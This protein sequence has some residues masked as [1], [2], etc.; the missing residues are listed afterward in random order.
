[1]HPAPCQHF[2]Q[3]VD[4][5]PSYRS[6]CTKKILSCKKTALTGKHVGGN[7]HMYYVQRME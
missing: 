2:F 1:M 5:T 6:T 3:P 7:I 4:K